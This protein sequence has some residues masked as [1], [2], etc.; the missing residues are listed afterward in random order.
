M[1]IIPHQFGAFERGVP[2]LQECARGAERRRIPPWLGRNAIGKIG[3]I[4]GAD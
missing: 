1:T 3:K 2:L 4:T